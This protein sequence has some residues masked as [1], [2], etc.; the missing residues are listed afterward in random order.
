MKCPCGCQRE[1]LSP[2]ATYYSARCR[3]KVSRESRAS[4]AWIGDTKLAIEAMSVLPSG[5]TEVVVT[6]P[7]GMSF[8][9]GDGF[10]IQF[11]TEAQQRWLDLLVL[12]GG[13]K[14][15]V[16]ASYGD[17]RARSKP[18]GVEIAVVPA[19][20]MPLDQLRGLGVI[21]DRPGIYFLWRGPELLYVGQSIHVETRL[22][23]HSGRGLIPWTRHTVMRAEIGQLERIERDYIRAYRPPHNTAWRQQPFPAA[24]GDEISLGPCS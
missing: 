17:G 11:S 7:E 10:D 14:R 16:R 22:R 23:E 13:A 3:L 4:A 2:R 1:V 9:V 20:V 12:H 24:R 18:I 19:A 6:L 21:G 15:T 5:E 8:D